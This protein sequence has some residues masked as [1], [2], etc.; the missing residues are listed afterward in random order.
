MEQVKLLN[1]AAFVKAL[2]TELKAKGTVKA[3]VN[4]ELE[5]A[6]DKAAALAIKTELERI[7]KAK[8]ESLLRTTRDAANSFLKEKGWKADG[9]RGQSESK[10]EQEAAGEAAAREIAGGES[11]RSDAEGGKT[12]HIAAT[13]GAYVEGMTKAAIADKSADKIGTTVITVVR[14]AAKSDALAAIVANLLAEYQEVQPA[15]ADDAEQR[16]SD[17]L[18]KAEEK[19]KSLPMAAQKAATGNAKRPTRKAAAMA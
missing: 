17:G 11:L 7:A 14:R 2:N 4:T 1:R 8:D 12:A 19:R 5:Q 16:L 10:L 6:T 13:V 15:P 18:A 3:R 9:T